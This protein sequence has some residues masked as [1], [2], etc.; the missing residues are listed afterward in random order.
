M[1]TAQN[2]QFQFQQARQA[3]ARGAWAEALAACDRL[4]R[5][6]GRSE[7]VLN[8]RAM[9]LL[10]LDRGPEAAATL[11]EAL[12]RK[13]NSA[14]MNLNAA[15]IDLA[16]GNPKG[17]KR[18]AM[19]AA[20]AASNDARVLY[21]AALLCRQ[22]GDYPTALRLVDRCQAREPGLSDAWYLKGSMLLDQ[23]D[24]DNAAIQFEQALAHNPANARAM[25]DLA[26]LRGE[27]DKDDRLMVMLEGMATRGR[28]TWARSCALFALADL[29]ARA[30]D[31]EAA[32]ALYQ[33][34]NELGNQVRPF[35]F[36]AWLRQ[37]D[38]TLSAYMDLV[39][40]GAPGHG[41]GAGLVFLVGMP[42]SGTS[43]CE[44]VLAGHPDV[45]AAGELHAMA[46]IET[47]AARGNT[48]ESLRRHYIEALPADHGR[49][50]LT[51]DKLPMN[52]ERVGLIHRLFPG[53]RFIHCTRHPL[54]VVLS[55]YQ[56]DFQAG[57]KWAFSL[58]RIAQVYQAQ[59]RLMKH[60]K[61]KLPE[62]ITEVRYEDLV[63]DLP[64][65]ASALTTFL[66]IEPD[67][68]MLAP[69]AI[70]RTVQTASRLQ[71][72]EAVHTRSVDKWRAYEDLLAPAIE[73][74]GDLI[75]APGK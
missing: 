55:C 34:A 32:A 73:R 23:G 54:D 21:Q 40:Q 64:A 60:W 15:R 19:T 65:T 62:H 1:T 12:K 14:G 53:A 48:D 72:R 17:A 30:G 37:Q 2:I 74:L 22:C 26:R 47:L 75:P 18:H 71:V 24:A 4:Q 25:A 7:E 59:D 67:D 51:T 35:N 10:A 44:Q 16:L 3:Y 31:A 36:D 39:P 38:E 43:L 49:Y 29:R 56:Q 33:R 9:S 13:P 66:G 8:L 41:N 63:G 42:R 68:A 20:R 5:Q 6:V 52:F 69:E 61:E 50:R 11:R 58:D 45:L 46:A 57:V 27:L 70:D 28:E